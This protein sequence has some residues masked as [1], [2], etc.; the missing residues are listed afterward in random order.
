M[1]PDRLQSLLQQELL[2]GDR[3]LWHGQPRP[4]RRALDALP[5]FIGGLVVTP[6]MAWLCIG[7]IRA[8]PFNAAVFFG[9]LLFGV[10]FVA[11]VCSLCGPFWAYYKATQTIYGITTRRAFIRSVKPFGGV[12]SRNVLPHA[13]GR[14]VSCKKYMFT[15]RG[16]LTLSLDDEKGFRNLGDYLEPSAVFHDIPDVRN[17]HAILLKMRDDYRRPLNPET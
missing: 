5:A 8:N 7:I 6:L 9:V 10:F 11:G 3:L 16:D 1:L 2:A 17:V 14:D 4:W 13:L 12:N 15:G